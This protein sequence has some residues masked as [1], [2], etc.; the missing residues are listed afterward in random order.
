MKRR[1]LLTTL[2]FSFLMVDCGNKTM[3]SE[4][5]KETSGTVDTG[6]SESATSDDNE[7]VEN[8]LLETD[9]YF[10]ASGVTIGGMLG[11]IGYD[12]IALVTEKEYS[13]TLS[14]EGVTDY[15]LTFEI[16][17]PTILEV[18]GDMKNGL[19]FKGLKQGGT[20]ITIR[21]ARGYQLYTNAINVRDELKPTKL[22]AYMSEEVKYYYPIMVGFDT[23]R[24]TFTA[25]TAGI[26][27]A[28][29][30]DNDYGTQS[31]TYTIGEKTS[32][33]QIDFYE[34][35]A[36]MDDDYASLKLQRI[37]IAVNGTSMIPYDNSGITLSLFKAVY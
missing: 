24:I 25:D 23:Y 7:F 20:M 6:I 18:T 21:D 1:K 3:D 36:T 29:E 27:Y 9:E 28:K 5:V 16:S 34:C 11:D 12:L 35:L 37:L 30:G 2:L 17:D 4:S 32:M 13:A 15:N 19:V 10:K 8:G 33:G 22:Q 26:F 14:E 31:F